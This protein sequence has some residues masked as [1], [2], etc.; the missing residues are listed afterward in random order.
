MAQRII[1]TLGKTGRLSRTK[2]LS[3]LKFLRQQEGSEVARQSNGVLA[4]CDTASGQGLIQFRANKL[5]KK[6]TSLSKHP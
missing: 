5:F 2:V 6:S 4:P 3:V 1:K